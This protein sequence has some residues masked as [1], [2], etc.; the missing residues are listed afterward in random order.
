MSEMGFG[1]TRDGVMGMAFKIVSKSQRPHPFK[2]GSAGR[3]WF[4]DFLRH[5]PK[6][7]IRSPQPLSYSRAITANQETINDFFGKLWAIY[8]RLNLVS[9]PRQIYNCDET[10]VT[11]VFK[12]GKVVVELGRRNIYAVSAAEK[13]WTHTILSCISASGLSLPSMMIY[14]HKD[15][16]LCLKGRPSLLLVTQ[17]G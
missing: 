3:G 17:D 7:T 8:G 6:L 10:G 11:I 12:N 9:K 14:P 5:H 16:F 2:N 13:G 4:E 1:L 15:L